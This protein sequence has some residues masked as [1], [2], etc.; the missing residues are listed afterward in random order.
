M[1]GGV[2]LAYSAT[3]TYAVWRFTVRRFDA[4]RDGEHDPWERT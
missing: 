1:S 4:E 3:L 2:L